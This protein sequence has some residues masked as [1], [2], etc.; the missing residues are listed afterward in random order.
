MLRQDAY[1]T[2]TNGDKMAGFNFQQLPAGQ[3]SPEKEFEKEV[4]TGRQQIQ[5]KYALQWQ[6]VNRNARTLG[7]KKHG[8]MLRQIDANAQAEMLQFNQ[9][10]EQQLARFNQIDRIAASGGIT[11]GKQSELKANMAYG[12]DVAGAMYPSEKS[13]PQQFGILDAH[14]NRLS[15]R[16]QEFRM[17]KERV[18]SLLLRQGKEGVAPG[19][20]QVW[21]RSIMV[22]DKKNKE[23][24]MGDWRD[25]TPEEVQERRMLVRELG[26]TKK[27]K[28]DILGGTDV[29]RRLVK[30][31]TRG[32]TFGDKIA[33]SYNKPTQAKENTDPLGLF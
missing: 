26:R 17:T 11:P 19:K 18:P 7:T 30:P 29:S 24:T 32:G 12:K 20:I 3:M 31:G 33:D 10:A 9:E 13:V 28:A 6:T 16:L 15:S 2:L 25:A 27:A 14:S 22:E 4:Q 23:F 5:Q 1:Y 8:D 21:D